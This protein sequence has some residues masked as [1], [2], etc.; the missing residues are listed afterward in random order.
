MREWNWLKT[1]STHHHMLLG[2]RLNNKSDWWLWTFSNANS[3]KC[4]LQS[5][6]RS[7][8]LSTSRSRLR[9]RNRGSRFWYRSRIVRPH[10][11]PWVYRDAKHFA[12]RPEIRS[13]DE[14]SPLSASSAST[15]AAAS[16]SCALNTVLGA[17][18]IQSL[19]V[20]SVSFWRIKIHIRGSFDK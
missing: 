7:Q 19:C 1:K 5:L 15:P 6:A 11:H 12:T 16:Y 13:L 20:W 3:A 18:G 8:G 17:T 10:A 2:V 4:H 9:S 14:C